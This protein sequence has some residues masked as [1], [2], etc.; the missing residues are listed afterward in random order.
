MIVLC[1]CGL[2]RVSEYEVTRSEKLSV[3]L[4]QV[5]ESSKTEA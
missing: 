5:G 2:T 3:E 1:G 4:I